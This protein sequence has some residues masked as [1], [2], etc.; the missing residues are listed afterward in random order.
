MLSAF[1]L[2]SHYAQNYAGIIGSSLS[3]DTNV[4]SDALLG[5]DCSLRVYQLFV[6]SHKFTCCEIKSQQITH[7]L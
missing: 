5:S 2:F 4:P 1:N 6:A 7:D 3:N